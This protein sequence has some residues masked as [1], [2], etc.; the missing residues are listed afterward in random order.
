VA[1]ITDAL[2]V[3]CGSMPRTNTAAFLHTNVLAPVHKSTKSDRTRAEILQAEFE[4]FWSNPFR[5]LAIGGL[6][7]STSSGRSAFTNASKFV[8]LH[9]K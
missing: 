4:F 5:E 1:L 9:P 8:V 7:A 3:L 6:L 2:S